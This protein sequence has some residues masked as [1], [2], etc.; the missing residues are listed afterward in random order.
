MAA[1]SNANSKELTIWQKA[2]LQDQEWRKDEL[3]DLVF[4][5]I[6]LFSVVLGSLYG[7]VGFKGL[8]CFVSFFIGVV[9]VPSFFWASYLGIDDVEYG[10]KMEIMGDSA[11]TGAALFVL[12]WVGVYTLFHA[13]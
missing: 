2:L 10:G 8:P 4:W 12:T 5:V 11:G 7:L 13:A 9:A 1:K 3:R 6:A